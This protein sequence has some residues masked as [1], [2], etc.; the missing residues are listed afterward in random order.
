MRMRSEERNNFEKSVDHSQADRAV[1]MGVNAAKK[2]LTY[3]ELND[4]LDKSEYD[5]EFKSTVR[6]A[7]MNQKDRDA[8]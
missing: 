6:N 2:D 4:L 3:K 1:L 5:D 8:R 7:Y